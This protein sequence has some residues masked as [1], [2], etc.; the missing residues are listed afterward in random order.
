MFKILTGRENVDA[1]QLFQLVTLDRELRGH[2]LKIFKQPCYKNVRKYLTQRII[3]EWNR[4]T[5]NV[6]DTQSV[7]SFKSRLDD[8]WSDMGNQQ[9]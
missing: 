3:N 1:S 8:Y 7:S 4:L 2:K 9:A 5:V 6:V